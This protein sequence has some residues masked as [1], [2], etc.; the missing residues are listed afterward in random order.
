MKKVLIIS[1]DFFDYHISIAKAFEALGYETKIETYDEPVHPFR[2]LMKWRHKFSWNKV[3]LRDKSRQRYSQYI[4]G[5]F[6]KYR[7]H[8]VFVFNGTMLQDCALEHFREA[9]AK[10]ALWMYD[11]VLRHDRKMCISHIDHVD[12]MCCF[13]STDVEFYRKQGKT[14]WFL[15]MACDTDIYHPIDDCGIKD[16]DILF[17]GTIYISPRRIR[18]LE[19]LVEKYKDR[20][21]VFYGLYKPYFKKPLGW[22]FRRHR[23]VF[24][25]R[26]ISPREVN[27]LYSRAKIALNIHNQQTFTGANP[28]LFEAS[29]AGAYQI[30]DKNPF[31]ENVF[32]AGE[33]GLYETDEELLRLIDYAL[34]HD[35]TEVAHRAYNIV[36]C[37]HTYIRRVEKILS[38]LD[39]DKPIQ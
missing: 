15:P 38:L 39:A 6:D 35:M 29:G 25:N 34:S 17:V 1:A 24:K 36:V 16:I 13:E 26:N 2:G 20:N 4:C 31:V 3:C 10:I 21:M 32:P 9:G 23:N 7:P 27:E 11:S 33:V 12:V 37:N 18:L 14:A 19:M 30:C 28:R 22:L 8:L 5:V